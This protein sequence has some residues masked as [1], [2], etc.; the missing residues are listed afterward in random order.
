M[1]KI[2]LPIKYIEKGSI[3]F[4]YHTVTSLLLFVFKIIAFY[5]KKILAIFSANIAGGATFGTNFNYTYP[6]TICVQYLR[7]LLSSFGGEDF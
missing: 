3:R 6:R 7:N 1:A 4:V 2:I 5:L